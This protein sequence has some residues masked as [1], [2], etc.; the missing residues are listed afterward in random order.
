[1]KRLLVALS[2]C[3]AIAFPASAQ[4]TVIGGGLAE[5]CY[6]AVKMGTQAEQQIE[7]LCSRALEQETMTRKNRAATYANRGIIRMRM[8]AFDRASSDFDRA[9]RLKEDFGDVLVNKGALLFYMGDYEGSIIALDR[10]LELDTGE[11]HIAHY[12][13]ALSREELGDVTGAYDD[14]L[15][16]AELKPDWTLVQRQLERFTVTGG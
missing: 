1:M 9:T 8:E 4:V 10:A 11:P 3:A 7:Q 12:N 14:F 5:D 16:A 2:A 6:L 15:I 13:R